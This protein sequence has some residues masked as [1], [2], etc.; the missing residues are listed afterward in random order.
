[1]CLVV[2]IQAVAN[3]L[4]ELNLRRAFE[5]ALAA[6]P[7]ATLAAVS[8]LPAFAAISTGAIAARAAVT[9]DASATFSGGT[10]LLALFLLFCHV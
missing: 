9:T 4:F 7:A 8:A 1:M 10:A 3:E 6:G 2:E 5:A